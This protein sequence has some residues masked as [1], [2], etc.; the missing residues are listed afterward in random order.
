MIVTRPEAMTEAHTTDML[1][2]TAMIEAM[3]MEGMPSHPERAHQP[4]LSGNLHGN[5]LHTRIM[6]KHQKGPDACLAE[7]VAS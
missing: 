7:A 5:V 3:D 1:S 4:H 6:C 2:M